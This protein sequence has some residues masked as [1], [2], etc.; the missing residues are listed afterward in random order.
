[1]PYRRYRRIRA[2]MLGEYDK[3]FRSISGKD[4]G[5]DEES[6]VTE[7][8]ADKNIGIHCRSSEGQSI[9]GQIEQSA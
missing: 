2:K 1:M 6:A 7:T 9:Q 5:L 3:K 4:L 8:E